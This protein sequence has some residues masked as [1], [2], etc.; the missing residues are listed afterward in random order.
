LLKIV[1]ALP[2]YL[3]ILV[4]TLHSKNATSYMVLWSIV[5]LLLMIYFLL[6]HYFI[7]FNLSIT[8]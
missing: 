5:Y 3:N 8:S 4:T 7:K 6:Y 2:L 1:L